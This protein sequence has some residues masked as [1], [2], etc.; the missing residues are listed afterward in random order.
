MDLRDGAVEAQALDI[1]LDLEEARVDRPRGSARP[2]R[3]NWAGGGRAERRRKTG[4]FA[5][6]PP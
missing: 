1:L 2:R 6:E 3:E 4:Q 5:D